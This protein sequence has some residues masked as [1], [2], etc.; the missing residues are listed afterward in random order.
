MR[1]GGQFVRSDW[2]HMD[3]ADAQQRCSGQTPNGTSLSSPTLPRRE[4][5][6]ISPEVLLEGPPYTPETT[7]LLTQRMGQISSPPGPAPS[8]Q[9]SHPVDPGLA[10]NRGSGSLL[11]RVPLERDHEHEGPHIRTFAR[12]WRAV[13]RPFPGRGQ[14]DAKYPIWADDDTYRERIKASIPEEFRGLV[15]LWTETQMLSLY[16]G[17]HDQF[18]RGLPVHGVYRGLQM[19]MQYFAHHHPR[20]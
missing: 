2:R 11:G 4:D 8:P 13:R 18:T 6:I 20:V 19:A 1:S 7:A 14:D 15:T 10:Q 3:W 16:H 12:V 9:A 5:S 17:I